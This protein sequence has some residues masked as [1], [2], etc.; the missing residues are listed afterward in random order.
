MISGSLSSR[1]KAMAGSESVIKLI[2]SNCIAVIGAMMFAHVAKNM[3]KI[4]AKLDESK[5]KIVF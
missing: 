3:T 1:P 5:K 4:S 2:Q